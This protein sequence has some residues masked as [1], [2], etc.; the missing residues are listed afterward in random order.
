MKHKNQSTRTHLPLLGG[1]DLGQLP[2]RLQSIQRRNRADRRY[3]ALQPSPYLRLEAFD[4][5]GKLLI[6]FN[7]WRTQRHIRRRTIVGAAHG[8]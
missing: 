3:E 5:L 6:K 7:N 2:M 8:G 1:N 4:C